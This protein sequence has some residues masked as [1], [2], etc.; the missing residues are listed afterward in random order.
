MSEAVRHNA[1]LD[2][3]RA[4]NVEGERALAARDLGAATRAFST[5]L[6]HLGDLA[7]AD[8]A[9][10]D[11]AAAGHLGLGRV[12]LACNDIRTADL[13]FDQVQRLRPT[14][15]DGFYWA[16]C[17]A[18]HGAN[19]PRAEW[20]LCAALDRDSR[21][22][23]AYLQRA[24]V[25]LRLRRPEPAL[26]DL[27]AAA[28]HQVADDNARLLMAALL[29][30]HGDA[31]Q[32]AALATD[33]SH[34]AAAAAI[35]GVAR[36]HQG[37][38]AAA[39][40]AFER[41][42][43]AGCHDDA[44][45]L[46]HGLASFQGKD[47]AGSIAA[48]RRLRDASPHHESL[49]RL[50]ATAHY[51]R[52]VERLAADD[53][54]G[55]ID[56]LH[57]AGPAGGDL[58]AVVEQA[59]LRDAALAIARGEWSSAS[60]RLRACG[61]RGQR[62]L[63]VLEFRDGRHATA[64]RL[65]R[66]APPSDPVARLGLAVSAVRDGR[67][68]DA[69]LHDLC[70]DPGTP[71]RIR[72]TS[73]RVLAAL[74]IRRGD[75]SAA[76][77][78]LDSFGDTNWLAVLA[79]GRYRTGRH[80]QLAALPD[81]PW[82]AV[83]DTGSAEVAGDLGGRAER[84]RVLLRCAD[85]IA[86]ARR[87]DWAEAAELPDQVDG[88]AGE[89]VLVKA[90]ACVLT[91]RR[92]EAAAQLARAA[93]R[94]PADQR[95]AHVQAVLHLHTLIA[96]EG[97]PADHDAWRGCI[98][99]WVSVLHDEAFWR[100]WRKHAQRRYG[101]PIVGDTI[102]AARTALDEFIEQRLPS[103]DLALLLRRER[104]AA[105]LLAR[106]GGLPGAAPAGPPLVCGPLRIAELGLHQR[107]GEFLRGLPATDDDTVRLFQEFSEIGLAMAQLAVGRPWAAAMAALDLRCASC[108]RTGGR[109]H[110]AMI[111]EPLMCEPECPE[112]D[113]LNPAFCTFTD[114]HDELAKASAALAARTLLGIAR[115][116]ITTAPMDLADARTCWRGA[117]TLAQ[118]FNQRDVVLR[119]VA[120]EALGRA[121]VLSQRRDLTG[122]IAVLDAVLATI[123]TK[124]T[125]E[126]DRV[127]TELG[128]LLNA[129][130]VRMYNE[131]AAN[132]EQAR[133]DLRRAV[134]LS[135]DR[136]RARFNLGLLLRKMSHRAYRDFDIAESIRLLSE[137]VHQFE[138]CVAAQNTAEFAEE[139]ELARQEL[140][141]ML[142]D[143]H[144]EPPDTEL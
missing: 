55:A 34:G 9:T 89:L 96:T 142:G 68:A 30:R 67:A 79:E 42:V 140:E 10:G 119:E 16:G 120:D 131:D 38:M 92:T 52:A 48:W 28:D 12:H 98:G 104:A 56:D 85:G 99:A 49:Q 33:V 22:G 73:G 4:A 63:A 111:S 94:A 139:L 110:P 70:A 25:R 39:A 24:Y 58:A 112:F 15:P 26:S 43:A 80:D 76:M 41:A 113:K 57:D 78:V 61:Q 29:V 116:D 130:G 1:V 36:Y 81:N 2:L 65:W 101:C 93:N 105:A 126:H 108:A 14:S 75:W 103:D 18:A 135:P 71:G 45:L 127:A 31:E 66:A 128:F 50:V 138:K 44:V 69:A 46:H 21:H 8:Q 27:L 7:D 13:R 109:T 53:F 133:A 19:Y 136:P 122:G 35:L 132:A 123:P 88:V 59:H 72:R 62:Y 37:R 141:S 20:L 54:S 86:A 129:R 83:V 6:D 51:A 32:A 40:A 5:A 115:V 106:L 97:Q 144:H 60:T 95:I 84:E 23:R 17:A 118:R 77:D 102:R 47:Y 87:G 64:E 117:V 82:Q 125:D 114:K 100:R 137:S 11:L 124:D 143:Y 3:V 134:T 91:G 121:R 74:H 90:V 107:L